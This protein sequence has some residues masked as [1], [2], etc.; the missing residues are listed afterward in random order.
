MENLILIILIIYRSGSQRFLHHINQPSQEIGEFKS[1][2]QINAYKILKI[3]F[4]L[5]HTGCSFS[6]AYFV[7]TRATKSV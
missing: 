7:I 2:F 4:V 1:V 3:L 5:V 6:R